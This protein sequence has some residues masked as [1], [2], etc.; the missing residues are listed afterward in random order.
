MTVAIQ[1]ERLVKASHK[2]VFRTDIQAM[3][4]LAIALVVLT[5]L[6][7]TRFSGGYVGV[8][9]FF[10]ISGFLITGHLMAELTR[11]DGVKLGR[12]YARRIRRLIPAA[13]VVLVS[14]LALVYAFL[15]YP[16]WERNAWEILSSAGYVENWFLASKSVNYSALNDAAS[17]VQHYWSLSV[18]EQ[19]YIVWPLILILAGTLFFG[20]RR[21]KA[22]TAASMRRRVLGVVMLLTVVSFILS[23]AYTAAAPAPA[24]FATFTRAWEFGVGGALALAGPYIRITQLMRNVFSF[25]GLALI[26]ATG[27][28]YGHTTPFPSGYAAVPVIGAAM[29]IAAGT[30]RAGDGPVVLLHDRLTATRPIQWLG[31]V[32][33]SVYLWHW[34]LI[35]IAPFA[36]NT[37]MTGPLR[38][39]VLMISLLLAGLT[40][41]F[42]EDGGQHWRFWNNSSP[43]A[44]AVMLAGFLLIAACVAGVLSIY[45]P[46]A[47]ADRPPATVAMK[48]CQGPAAMAPGADCPDRFTSVNYVVMTAKNEYYYT[49]PECGDFMSELTY[50]EKKTTMTCDFSAGTSKPLQVALV[51]DSHVQQWQGAVFDLARRHHW[52][53]TTS[54]FGGCPAT[55]AEFIGFRTSWGAADVLACRQWSQDISKYIAS[56]S[57]DVVLTSM[58]ARDQLSDD[59]S[60]RP[61]AQQMVS[62]LASYWKRWTAK[63]IRVLPIVNPPYNA[64]V[65][66]PDCLML[67]E[68]DP[69]SCARPRAE[70]SPLDPIATASKALK[71]QA[72]DLTDR[73]CDAGSCYAAIGGVPVY[74]DADHLNLEYVRLLEPEVANAITAATGA[75]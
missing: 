13:M 38:V 60:G 68:K 15:P 39:G 14:S 51:G 37:S 71:L 63:G 53:V 17:T 50:G 6:W 12:F 61:Q 35:V 57:P 10:V 24:Y 58:A 29:I 72:L 56:K 23:I 5:H 27:I 52:V 11:T 43:R 49:P 20:L 46:R 30:P 54:Y 2:R 33:Y 7:P 45:Y 74:Y 28:L 22:A 47:A 73:F 44:F 34:P 8:D 26:V 75:R 55:D 4:A 70:A 41:H 67:N 1:P 48:P 59:G 36:L 25:L 3:R 65:R 21:G 69:V 19:F 9:V 32:S 16:R 42:I 40:K 62:G 64:E 31:A 66:P 18:E